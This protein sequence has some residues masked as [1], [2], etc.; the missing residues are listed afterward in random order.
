[1]IAPCVLALANALETVIV[2]MELASANQVSPVSTVLFL[3]ALLHAL[4]TDNASQLA[5][6]WC[7]S[8]MKATR[9]MTARRRHAPMTAL[10]TANALMESAPVRMVGVEMIVLD[11]AP[12][13]VKDAAEMESVWRVNVIAIPDGVAMPVT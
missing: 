3:H 8:A 10:A 1:M 7:A 12:D 9:V 11:V 6:R 4:E 5:H 2:T 13:M